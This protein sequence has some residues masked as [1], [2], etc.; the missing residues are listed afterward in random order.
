VG[1][2]RP[3][4]AKAAAVAASD[5]A[6]IVAHTLVNQ[7]AEPGAV[8]GPASPAAT[9]IAGRNRFRNELI[10]ASEPRPLKRLS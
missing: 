7:P 3:D 6:I 2:R 5:G 10:L 1:P 8:P 4:A 9:P